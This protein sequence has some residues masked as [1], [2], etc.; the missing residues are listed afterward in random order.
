[1]CKKSKIYGDNLLVV[2]CKNWIKTV[3]GNTNKNTV[4]WNRF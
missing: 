3:A 2:Q 1:M 4:W